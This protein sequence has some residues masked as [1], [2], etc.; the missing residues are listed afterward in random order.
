VDTQQVLPFGTP[1]EVR[2]E[3][4]HRV[5]DLGPDGFVWAAVHNI[6]S[7]VPPANVIAAFEAVRHPA[8]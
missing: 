6:Q 1:D 7:G 4:R 5:Q 2:A 8:E 3:V